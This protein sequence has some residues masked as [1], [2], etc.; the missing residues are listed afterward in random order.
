MKT[1]DD[2]LYIIPFRQDHN[3]FATV[4]NGNKVNWFTISR[5][6]RSSTHFL[7]RKWIILR[8]LPVM[9]SLLNIQIVIWDLGI[10]EGQA[11]IILLNSEYSNIVVQTC[12]IFN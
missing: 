4:Y 1:T 10:I 3:T 7:L 6:E 8:V 9:A 2:N 5:K 11:F 12:I